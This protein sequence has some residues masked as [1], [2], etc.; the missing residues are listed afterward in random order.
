M[1][2]FAVE[3]AANY[4]Y[5]VP[6]VHV[7]F[8]QQEIGIDVGYWRSV[9]HALNCF[10]AESFM[11]ELAVS[12][13][14]RTRSSSAR[15]CWKSSRASS[16]CSTSSPSESRFGYPPRGRF[17][18]LAVM[19]GYGTYMAQVAEIFARRT[20]R[21][22]C[23]ASTAR[24]DCGQQVNPDTVV[25]QIESSDHLR[26]LGADVGRDQHPERARAADQLRQ[27]PGRAHERR[28]AHRCL[29]HRQQRSARRHRRAGNCTGGA[30]RL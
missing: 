2:P 6:N 1:D 15:R 17:H 28:A 12:Q 20:A 7:D 4:P 25:A 5:D 8:Q 3:A 27:L 13:R 14:R 21:S 24:V 18:G 30:G 9:S 29:R 11:D 19:E 16:R 26:L 10:V 23:T 22:R